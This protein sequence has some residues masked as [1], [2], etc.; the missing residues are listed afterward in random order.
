MNVVAIRALRP[1]L[2]VVRRVL[3][4][5]GLRIIQQKQPPTF[6]QSNTT[7]KKVKD[8]KMNDYFSAVF[9]ASRRE[10][11]Y[12]LPS[13]ELIAAITDVDVEKCRDSRFLTM[14]NPANLVLVA[15][16]SLLSLISQRFISELLD[17]FNYLTLTLILIACS[18]F[19]L[20]R[21]N[22]FVAIACFT[23]CVVAYYYS[24][25]HKVIKNIKNRIIGNRVGVGV[26]VGVSGGW[27]A[28]ERNL[29]HRS[30]FRSGFCCVGLQRSL[31]MF[32]LRINEI[33]Q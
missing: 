9:R 4:E 13:S 32:I 2:L 10:G 12:H 23:S 8:I 19:N 11:V 3:L 16:P 6:S 7:S 27:V 14:K 26:G 22:V 5:A 33:I 30:G 20:A 15:I 17:A 28:R 29:I 24:V 25:Y 1:Q 18:I 21:P 31:T